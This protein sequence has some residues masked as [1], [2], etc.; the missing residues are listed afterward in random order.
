MLVMFCMIAG[1]MRVESKLVRAGAE[2]GDRGLPTIHI[3][4][5]SLAQLCCI[6][7]SF[8]VRRRGT[9]HSS[10]AVPY[11]HRYVLLL[12]LWSGYKTYIPSLSLHL[13]HPTLH[14]KP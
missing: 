14:T 5:C 1:G 7:L 13:L 3:S 6:D 4:C 11:K 9:W 12:S 8:C 10:R 2:V